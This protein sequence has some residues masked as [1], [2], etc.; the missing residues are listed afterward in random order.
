MIFPPLGVITEWPPTNYV[1]PVTRGSSLFIVNTVF[2][3]LAGLLVLLRVYTRVFVT[4]WFG[5]DDLFICLALVF[6]IGLTV[7]VN[8]GFSSFGWNRY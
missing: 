6:S 5:W 3:C 2:I 8:V 4:N 1:D 7:G